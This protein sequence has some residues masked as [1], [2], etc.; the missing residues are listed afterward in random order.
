MTINNCTIAQFYSLNA[1]DYALR[2]TNTCDGIRYPVLG[3]R[4]YN[5]IIT[6][7]KDDELLGD[8]DTLSAYNY[9]FN[10]CLLKTPEVKNGALNNI[11]FESNDSAVHS[12][13]NFIEINHD[14]LRY[15]FR[16]DSLS[17][18]INT[19][20]PTTAMKTDLRGKLRKST[21]S[22]G[23]YEWFEPEKR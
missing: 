12:H 18:A 5:T 9:D 6:G 1:S 21:P 20:D 7:M 11:I 17:K 15:D 4:V 23:C 19:G 16:L 13:L 8:G 22:I 10:Y 2:F 3:M 14:S